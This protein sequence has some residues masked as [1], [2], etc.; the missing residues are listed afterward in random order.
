MIDV[1]EIFEHFAD[2]YD[3]EMIEYMNEVVFEE[4][5]YIFTTRES[6]KQYGYCTYC[7]EKYENDYTMH[8]KTK[9][10]CPECG[11]E[12]NVQASGYGRKTMFDER[13]FIWYEKSQINP[14]IIV[15]RGIYAERDWRGDDYWN[16]ETEFEDIILYV[17]ENDNSRAIKR[18][19][20]NPPTRIEN[21]IFKGGW[22]ECSSVYSMYNQDHYSHIEHFCSRKSI[23]NAVE[24]TAYQY[25]CW[26]E[27]YEDDMVQY[28]DM[29][30]KWPC[31]EYL[32]KLGFE[33][34][35]SDKLN[36]F[37]TYR[38]VN[39]RGKTLSDVLKIDNEDLHEIKENN[40]R[41]SFLELKY[42]Q[43]AKDQG[44]RISFQEAIQ[45]ASQYGG[46]Y[47][48][49]KEISKYSPL[50]KI[51]KYITKQYKKDDKNNYYSE[52]TVLTD[53]RDYI[54]DCIKLEMDLQ[55]DK[56]LY[57]RDLY[58]AHQN[59]IKQVE[60][61]ENKEFD[62]EITQRLPELRKY[63]YQNKELIIRPARSS[64][65]LIEEGKALNHC[66][67]T[68]A[69]KYAKK[70]TII[71][72]I[73]KIKEPNKPYYTVEVKREEVW[74]VRGK[75]NCAKNEEVDLFLEEFK[76]NIFNKNQKISA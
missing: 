68:Y 12:C 24:N 26:E 44:Q 25:S 7:G 28:F 45:I 58:R 57:P 16:V 53:W 18:E 40:I 39:W 59:T 63:I 66:V 60:I 32:T 4:S 47:K 42:F 1:E 73:R 29:Y 71:L 61:K 70:E 2:E 65:E 3:P 30:S 64:L 11:S 22:V 19:S 9:E 21:G 34:L 49:I 15:A 51:I 37:R 46:Y 75:N 67:G 31:I 74:Q 72:F 38:A 5:R 20:W 36:G 6:G 14:E 50:K 17:F 10:K 69:E 52:R 62:K 54:Y 43:I 55:D 8:H 35:V 56:V 48:D 33:N 23:E 41:F 27:Y 13:Y 76:C